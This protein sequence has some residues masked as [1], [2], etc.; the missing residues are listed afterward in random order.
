MRESGSKKSR[1]RATELL[2]FNNKGVLV[3]VTRSKVRT[4]TGRAPISVRW[5]DVN[6]GGKQ[7]PNYP[8]RLVARQPKVTDRPGQT[9]FAPAPSLEASRTVLSLAVTKIRQHI[10]D[11][12][13]AGRR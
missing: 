7:N 11:W 6:K 3:K 5:V 13:Q 8:S 4:D 10:P 9:Y 12:G 2:Y 1:A